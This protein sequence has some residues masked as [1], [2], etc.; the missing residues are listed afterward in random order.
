MHNLALA[1]CK[2]GHRVTGSDDEIYEPARSR[3]DEYGLLPEAPGWFPDKLHTGVDQVILGMHARADNPELKRAR[4]LGLPVLSFPEFIAQHAQDKKR[5]VVAGSHGKTTTTAMIMHVL[6]TLHRPFDYLVG[7]Q[8]EGFDTMVQLSDAPIIVLEGD[9]Y[10]SSAVDLRPK[11]LHY[12]PHIAVLTGIAW[13]HV[14]VFPT[15]ESYFAQ[16]EAFLQSLD[17]QGTL[18]FYFPDPEVRRALRSAPAT[19]QGIP[20][21]G[22]RGRRQGE[23]LF[24]PRWGL[25]DVPLQI[26]GQH[27]LANMEA[28]YYVCQELGVEDDDFFQAMASFRGAA[29]RLQLLAANGGRRAWL[30]FAHAPSKVRATVAA[31]KSQYEQP[32][33]ACLELHTF[34][35]LDKRFLPHYAGALDAAE[36]AVVYYDPR[37]LAHKKLPPLEPQ[38]VAAAFRR[39]DLKIANAPDEVPAYLLELKP[40]AS[41]LLLM[42]S[43]QFG[44]ID[45]RKLARDFVG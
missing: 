22:F 10:P 45:L 24:L 12:R 3:L 16:F 41:N 35:S 20:Y 31:V 2:A 34:S 26:F 15:Y 11:F 29:R 39:P 21:H 28:A 36:W 42:S 30:D 1:L 33:L 27:N 38:E 43:G 4:E 44:K 25:P 23:R 14:N 32:L 7:A 40:K 8:L 37:V 13:D 6:R 19:L 17:P 5:V 18:I 9:E